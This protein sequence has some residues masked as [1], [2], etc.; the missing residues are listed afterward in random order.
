MVIH[1]RKPVTESSQSPLNLADIA[2]PERWALVFPE[3]WIDHTGVAATDPR[4]DGKLEPVYP[5]SAGMTAEETRDNIIDV[6]IS[7]AWR[8]ERVVMEAIE[9]YIEPWELMRI[10]EIPPTTTLYQLVMASHFPKEVAIGQQAQRVLRELDIAVGLLAQRRIAGYR[11]H[12]T[13]EFAD[14]LTERALDALKQPLTPSEEAAVI[15]LSRTF[16][17][18]AATRA[19][20]VCE[21]PVLAPESS[22]RV[23]AVLTAAMVNAG[24]RVL[25]RT[26]SD[27]QIDYLTR[28]LVSQYPTL[29]VCSSLVAPDAESDATS[30]ELR[31][32]ILS[33]SDV[34]IGPI[35]DDQADHHYDLVIVWHREQSTFLSDRVPAHHL[36]VSASL[37]PADEAIEEWAGCPVCHLDRKPLPSVPIMDRQTAVDAINQ[38]EYHAVW[39][40]EP[41]PIDYGKCPPDTLEVVEEGVYVDF[42]TPGP[43]GFRYLIDM[44]RVDFAAGFKLYQQLKNH[45]AGDPTQLGFVSQTPERIA[46]IKQWLAYEGPLEELQRQLFEDRPAYLTFR[47]IPGQQPT[48]FEISSVID[49]LRAAQVF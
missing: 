22:A 29:A 44:D 23:C 37:M 4:F 42:N 2:D 31:Q 5:A 33:Q 7:E 49:K 34:V 32:E 13:I 25:W 43:E 46:Q 28:E 21:E 17:Q 9:D 45:E 41:T 10:L 48:L 30:G 8:V 26:A 6:T 24:G 3:T 20:L 27:R 38:G 47:F 11:V 39:F 14:R 15:R 36:F 40:W 18:E 35:P 19:Q 1:F 16:S 12:R